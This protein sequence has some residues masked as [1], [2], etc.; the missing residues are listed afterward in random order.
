MGIWVRGLRKAH[1][2]RCKSHKT[3]RYLHRYTLTYYWSGCRGYTTGFCQN[4]REHLLD[5][6]SNSPTTYF[7]WWF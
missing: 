2:V 3:G 5:A 7:P 6:F 4:P 1:Q